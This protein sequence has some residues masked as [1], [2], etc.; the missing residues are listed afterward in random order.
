MMVLADTC[1]LDWKQM[2]RLMAILLSLAAVLCVGQA[3]ALAAGDPKPGTILV[4]ELNMRSGPGRHNP[5][6]ATLKKGARVYV[7]SYEGEWVRILYKDQTGFI[8]NRERYLR[9]EESASQPPENPVPPNTDNSPSDE[10]SREMNASKQKLASFSKEEA[11]VIEALESTD[12][13]LDGARKTVA[14]LSTEL[15]AIEMRIRELEGQ[16]RE[17]EVRAA[18]NEAYVA[19]RLAALYKLSW[20]G[21]FNVL[22]SADSMFEFFADKRSLEQILAYDEAVLAELN[23]DKTHMQALLEK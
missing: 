12:K 18:A 17:V 22:A 21:K 5:P 15:K 7:L 1:T 16:Y 11:A 14:R 6:I 19:G 13:A 9:I 3:S 8:L 4:E 20:L 10:L 2:I 23:R